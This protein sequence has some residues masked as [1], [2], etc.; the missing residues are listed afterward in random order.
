MAQ[1]AQE[2]LAAAVPALFQQDALAKLSFI[3]GI[4]TLGSCS[5]GAALLLL[6][7]HDRCRFSA[8]VLRVSTTPCTISWGTLNT[9]PMSSFEAYPLLAL[10]CNVGQVAVMLV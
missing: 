5:A 3:L 2:Q 7:D 1:E 8:T 10:V 4:I 6:P 9:N